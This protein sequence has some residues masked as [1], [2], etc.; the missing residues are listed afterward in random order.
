[1]LS[2]AK[3]LCIFC[4]RHSS[5]ASSPTEAFLRCALARASARQVR[6]KPI[7]GQFCDTLQSSWF[8]EKMGSAADNFQLLLRSNEFKRPLIEF[9]DRRVPAAH[10]Q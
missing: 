6:E 10:N 4:L 3:D 1:M 9:N 5:K 8:F 2:A 7:P